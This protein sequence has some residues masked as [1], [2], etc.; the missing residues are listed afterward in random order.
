MSEVR[1]RLISHVL[2]HTTLF[3]TPSL[4]VCR[5]PGCY[6]F[7]LLTRYTLADIA[8]LL[9]SH[10]DHQSPPDLKRRLQTAFKLLKASQLSLEMDCG[11]LRAAVVVETIKLAIRLLLLALQQNRTLL[12]DV[13]EGD[14]RA[15][16]AGGFVGARTGL[17]LPPMRTMPHA[18]V[19]APRSTGLN[20]ALPYP[21][22]CLMMLRPLVYLRACAWCY[23]RKG[24]K[25]SGR[26]P[27]HQW[28]PW[29]I[30]SSM[31]MLGVLILRER[32]RRDMVKPGDPRER[33]YRRRVRVMVMG[34][35]LRS[36]M[37]DVL[38]RRP[39][40]GLSRTW[41]RIPV[42][43]RLNYV[44]YYLF[45]QRFYYGLGAGDS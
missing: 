37:F 11:G 23:S 34:I 1:V 26:S 4:R 19:A 16:D 29:L 36:P 9:R 14:E 15:E 20:L 33:E 32:L 35:L 44:G 31:D 28:Q 17:R 25:G 24:R 6:P 42:L 13:A 18:V 43:N 30:A 5:T 3:A 2:R 21:E 39:L 38:L 27:L 22:D 41:E 12:V 10:F 40:E 7:S 8:G 45:L